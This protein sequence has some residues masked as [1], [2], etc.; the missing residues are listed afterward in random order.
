[1]TGSLAILAVHA[2]VPM[3][4]RN[5][6]S[7]RLA[8]LLSLM[9]DEGHRVALLA[10]S[11]PPQQERHA[12]QLEELG[13]EVIRGD[14][15]RAAAAG[16]PATGAQ[17]DIAAL[18]RDGRWDLVWL[19]EVGIVEQYTPLV[20]MFAPCARIVADTGDVNWLREARGAELSGD[21]AARAAAMRTRQREAGAYGAVDGLV[22]VSEADGQVLGELASGVPVFV[23]SNI[24][25]SEP[26]GPPWHERSGIVFVGHFGHA[27]NV[28]AV[29]HFHATAWQKVLATLPDA[30]LTIVGPAP[31]PAIAALAGGSVTVT[32]WVESV[33]PYLDAARV[34]IAPLR[35]GAGVKGK[36]GEA[37]AAGLPV[38]G[39]S[40]ALEGMSLDHGTHVLRADGPDE[41]A[42]AIVRLHTDEA[43]WARLATA[44]R[45][46]AQA[47]FGPAA[48]RDGL[49]K[50]LARLAGPLWLGGE[51]S[52]AG[53]LRAHRPGESSTLVL[54]IPPDPAGQGEALKRIGELVRC[55]GHDP[56]RIPDI[57][58]VPADGPLVL[59]SRAAAWGAEPRR[60]RSRRAAVV[61]LIPDDPALARAQVNALAEAGLGQ[62]V[63]LLLAA[64]GLGAETLHALGR[65][66]S[67]AE[68]VS[69]ERG[70]G[71][72]G[73]L[74]RAVAATAAEAVIVLDS[75]VHP[76]RGFAEPL[77]EAVR[78]GASLAAP[79]INRG[80]PPAQAFPLDCLAARR[81]TWLQAPCELP[82]R[83]GFAETQLAA[84]ALSLGPLRAV[85]EST[86]RRLHGPPATVVVCSHNRAHELREV[87][88][89]VLADGLRGEIV[90]VDNA[91]SDD[92]AATGAELAGRHPD[93]VR[94][95]SEPRPGLSHARNAGLAA[96]R[97]DLVVFLDDDA[98]PAPGWLAHLTTGLARPGV[99]NAGG[100]ICALWPASRPPGWPQAGVERLFGVLDLGDRERDI[101]PPEHVFGGN[102]AVRRS[103]LQEAGGFDPQFGV[104]PDTRLGGEEI[105]AAEALHRLGLG[106][107]RWI[108]RAAVGHLVGEE[109]MAESAIVRRSL[110]GG[111]ERA[112]RL[113]ATDP[114]RLREAAQRG[115]HVLLAPFPL[116]GELELEEAVDR[117]ARW[118]ADLLN[119]TL[120][121]D[122]LGEVAGCVAILGESELRAGDLRLR[123]RPEHARGVLAR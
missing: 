28:D 66:A 114:H 37:L 3:R 86:V 64:D 47:L 68:I 45:A 23:I 60:R 35:F 99:A 115:A 103:L 51:D 85:R 105:A 113:A 40:V 104:S 31:P 58:L 94:M 121:A 19:S 38:V 53:Y 36:V 48:A 62:E 118:P 116:G 112:R 33:R 59:P 25:P 71:R 29:L 49:A 26:E 11:A 50:L 27:P 100:P 98:R 44:G 9:V 42:E 1:M 10:R 89:A 108:P 22:A 119:R 78:A 65:S 70:L 101:A 46:R 69:C 34:A 81:Q 117:L 16:W 74:Q 122:L 97:H 111:I 82:A 77:L 63:E 21:P 43:L 8:R 93:V 55:L 90:L 56:E 30:K 17:L 24:H 73:I 5:S 123:V 102:W 32:G 84:W 79:L 15:Q 76:D 2:E 6:L 107:T 110:L 54:P 20:R 83:E 67:G 87:V 120:A 106:V 14:P 7:L 80:E 13:V 91:S 95:V 92:T 41:L 75:L 61:V 39:T 109:R 4:D 57:A 96:A 18:L 12:R 88:A 52:V 72:R